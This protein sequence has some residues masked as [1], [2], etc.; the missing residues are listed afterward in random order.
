MKPPLFQ[1]ALIK[2]PQL[3]VKRP[4]K[5]DRDKTRMLGE[6]DP[7]EFEI[8]TNPTEF[9]WLAQTDDSL[10]LKRSANLVQTDPARVGWRRPYLDR[11]DRYIGNV[12]RGPLQGLKW[13]W[14]WR[15][16][17]QRGRSTRGSTVPPGPLI[18]LCRARRNRCVISADISYIFTSW[19]TR[20]CWFRRRRGLSVCRS[21]GLSV[22]RPRHITVQ[23]GTGNPR[24][25]A[26][27]P[28][29]FVRPTLSAPSAKYHR[30]YLAFIR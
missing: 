2:H 18:Y 21:V 12:Q 26:A 20:V 13:R 30:K 1:L 22:G 15:R 17:V 8:L 9:A 27:Y 28:A 19:R 16:L 3:H 10:A 23:N 14:G 7:N 6:I 29:R 11:I 24:W 5:W 4:R 25:A